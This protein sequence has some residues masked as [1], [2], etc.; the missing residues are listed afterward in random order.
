[1]HDRGA[2]LV[3]RTTLR[4]TSVL[5]DPRREDKGGKRAH[6]LARVFTAADLQA[7]RPPGV[8]AADLALGLATLPKDAAAPVVRELAKRPRAPA[9][10]HA[11]HAVAERA[12]SGT[13]VPRIPARWK[14]IVVN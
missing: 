7:E 5:R 10:G 13:I 12:L 14:L 3:P 11:L 4:V 8:S 2:S 9:F 1:M 6:A